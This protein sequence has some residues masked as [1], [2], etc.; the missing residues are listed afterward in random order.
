[1]AAGAITGVAEGSPEPLGVSLV[2]GGINMAVWSEHA[3][4]IEFC[5]FD[6]EGAVELA[7]VPLPG[8]TGPVFHGR[9]E[10]IGEGA[11]YG[12]RAHGPYDPAR[13]QR[14][15]PD[16]L[17]LDPYALAIDRA[18]PLH[19]SM[20]GHHPDDPTAPHPD[21]SGPH[22][23]K[24]V[25]V[26]EPERAAS[27]PKIAWGETVIYELHV[28]GFTRLHPDVPEAIRGTFAGLAHPAAV[29]HL[30]R[31]GVTSVELMPCAAWIDEARLT[32]LG[33]TNYWG[34]NPV[35]LMVPDPRLAPGGW[36]E[37]R[38]A[39]AALGAAGI[40]TLLDVV[41]NHT[42]ETDEF[43]HTVSLRGLDNAAYYR[44]DPADPSRY[45]ND[46]GTGNVLALDRPAPLR[47]AMDA[48]RAWARYGGVAGFRFDLATVL[49]R[50]AGGFDPAAPLLAA[51]DQDPELRALKRIAEPWDVGP[52][53]YQLGHFPPGWAEW[54]DRF[55]SDLRGFWRGDGVS[56]GELARRLAG[57][58]DIFAGR[59]PSRSVNY[60]VAHD[61][62][63][64]AD[65]VAYADKHNTANGEDGRDGDADNHSWNNGVE[66]PSDDPAVRAARAAD[67]RALLASLILAR[68]APMLAMG[69]ELGRSQGGNN[70]AYAQD[71][72]TSWLDWAKADAD[73]AAFTARLVAIR[74]AH[75]ALC[76]DRFLTGEAVGA[77]PYPDVEWRRADGAAPAAADWDD[78]NGQTLVMTLAEPVG[79][80]LD[81]VIV[82]TH[83]GRS[84]VE[85]ALPEPRDGFAWSLLADT[86]DPARAGPA[87]ATLTLAARS[88]A[89][90]AEEPARSSRPR[91]GTDPAVLSRLARAAGVAGTWE[92][93]DG[94]RHTVSPDTEKALLAALRL[95]ADSTQAALDSLHRLRQKP[96]LPPAVVAR[97]GEPVI[98]PL[99]GDVGLRV[100]LSI[101]DEAGELSRLRAEAPRAALPSLPAGRYR[102]R[103]EDAPDAVC[104]LTVA[105]RAC[106]WPEA[107]ADGRRLTG[108]TAQVYAL[109]RAGDQGVGDFTTLGLLGAE[110]ARRGGA[111][112]GINPL[113]ARFC[114]RRDRASPYYP[115]DRRFLDPIY[116]DLPEAAGAAPAG[117]MIDY[118]GVW[119]AKA[120]AL[121]ARLAAAGDD[122]DLAAFIAAGGEAL[123]RFATFEA[124][125][126]TRPGQSWRDWPPEL[127]DASGAGVRAFAG[128]NAARVRRHMARQWLCERQLAEAATTAS[129]LPLGFCRDLAIG[130]APDGAE[131]WSQGHLLAQGVSLGAPPDLLG[132]NGQIWG[133]PPFD[134][135]AL[136]ADGY[137]APAA[138]YAA[139]MRHAGALRIDHVMGLARQFWIPDGAD[140]SAGAYVDFPLEDLLGV[141]ALES[142]RARCLI[143]GEDLGTV[144]PG[145]RVRMAEARLLSYRVLPF[146]RD[147]AGAFRPPAVYPPLA[148]G[149]V[150]THDLPPLAGWWE[151]VDIEERRGLGLLD[152][153]GA[154]AA[155]AERAGERAALIAALAEAGLVD[156]GPDPD[157]PLSDALAAAIHRFVART[158]TALALAQ[159]EDLAGARESVNLPGTDTE[160]PNWRR[161]IETPLEA[162]FDA[163]RA[164]AILAALHA[165]RD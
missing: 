40:E 76:A 39:T 64:L 149:C 107:L 87:A 101:E 25:V 73:L 37:V 1:V 124:I 6:A 97:L 147:A 43:G 158:P 13:G 48:L 77:A 164:Q 95:P 154:V 71:N 38:A 17:L 52:A 143:I 133:L 4:A 32:A 146:E 117:P 92:S 121:E 45:V 68:G 44:L 151:G 56:T 111:V 35:A 100:W 2:P 142:E 54:N 157:G 113:H 78:P 109:S 28:R 49:G 129:A 65:L 137:A 138:L 86:A 165:E 134:P 47:L 11:R 118:P 80:E 99:A 84:P 58:E 115:S 23:A 66:G 140:G 125:A 88:V 62:F 74:K 96:P 132:P 83:R 160:R 34:Y 69:A 98:L 36:A 139:N 24:A 114:D 33:L 67:Q 21:D 150:A 136:K 105:P 155:R 163:P 127:R 61:G 51:I 159:A 103:R 90:L 22:M 18:F 27:P 46:A 122:P 126:E 85:I 55:R 31:L 8:R 130:A 82:A 60:V 119:A 112:L 93:V 131:A 7:R 29:A 42:G 19:P 145:L 102:I 72:E 59:R 89:V 14:F 5:L 3:T 128:T 41:L 70:N 148:W 53:G 50:R 116:L 156:P 104:V 144:P 153:A 57:S 20:A 110:T 141:L 152:A 161:R 79:D 120:K 9:I 135:N 81:R 12:L 10:G 16:K 75:P 108:V 30:T 123:A 91:A 162:L 63:T 15:N 26:A 94:A 106:H